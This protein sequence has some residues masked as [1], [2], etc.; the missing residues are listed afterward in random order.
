VSRGTVAFVVAVAIAAVA[1]WLW[2]AP[3]PERPTP[4]TP[5]SARPLESEPHV[6]PAREAAV[7]DAGPTEPPATSSA[8]PSNEIAPEVGAD[9]AAPVESRDVVGTLVVIDE[10]GAEHRSESGSFAIDSRGGNDETTSVDVVDGR[11]SASLPRAGASRIRKIRLGDRP[12]VWIHDDPTVLVPESGVLDIRARWPRASTLHV[13]DAA[14]GREL[15]DV[16][17][18]RGRDWLSTPS[19]RGS[20]PIDVM[21]LLKLESV[22][23]VETVCVGSSGFG[24]ARIDLDLANGGERFVDLVA[25]GGIDVH[26]AGDSIARGWRL[27]VASTGD[28]L[29]VVARRLFANDREF[30]ID[31]L[32]PG[33]Y[34]VSVLD[35]DGQR[36]PTVVASKTAEVAA[37]SRTRVEL[38]LE[39]PPSTPSV[40]VAGVLRVARAWHAKPASLAVESLDDSGE[41]KR[42][43]CAVEEPRR[44]DDTD[45]F[46]FHADAVRP[47]RCVLRLDQPIYTFAADVPDGGREDLVLEVP[48]PAH[49]SL[50]VVD[51]SSGED[52]RGAEVRW[53]P[54]RPDGVNSGSVEDAPCDPATGRYEFDAPVTAIVVQ[55][56]HPSIAPAGLV[57]DVHPGSNECTLT[58]ERACG[59]RLHV[60]EGDAT[61]PWRSDWRVRFAALD[62]DGRLC[63]SMQ[64][65]GEFQVSFTRPGRYRMT[66]AK[67]PEYRDVPNAEV[68]VEPGK[69]TDVVVHLERER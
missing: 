17:V 13:R 69:F 3:A 23:H 57:L 36:E 64:S 9:V 55:A 45:V 48:P 43:A 31:G 27:Q 15:P 11:W 10:Q 6:E 38:L 56:A 2:R 30:A 61:L 50:R 59:V 14:T 68:L 41:G 7:R 5:P 52:F 21:K 12:A 18:V 53:N 65:N 67:P 66:F 32:G 26:L 51:A 62:S 34:L 63:G 29:G 54:R 49:V 33:T 4:A 24:W 46:A 20:S 58:V 60:V 47:G 16:D 35:E 22:D 37:G 39:P 42:V 44:E 1:W 19:I 28:N 25:G 8:A 40:R